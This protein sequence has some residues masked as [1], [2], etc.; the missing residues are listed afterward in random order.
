MNPTLHTCSLFW[1]GGFFS[2]DIQS[3]QETSLAWFQSYWSLTFVWY[4]S[5]LW[6][7]TPTSDKLWWSE[8]LPASSPC[9]GRCQSPPG[10]DS[11]SG[12]QKDS[13]STGAVYFRLEQNASPEQ[14]ALFHLSHLCR[15]QHTQLS[16][17]KKPDLPH[18]RWE[19]C[20]NWK[21]FCQYCLKKQM[22]SHSL[23]DSQRDEKST[24]HPAS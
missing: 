12:A 9:S 18:W 4:C 17:W 14:R 6:K 16:F 20:H 23:G 5:H 11:A 15:L 21:R 7:Q 3:H 2:S 8:W 19:V 1:F 13:H 10:C 24:L 22:C